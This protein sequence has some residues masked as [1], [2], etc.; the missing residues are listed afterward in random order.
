MHS[1][2]RRTSEL[3]AKRLDDEN[4]SQATAFNK[5]CSCSALFSV[6]TS[7]CPVWPSPPVETFLEHAWTKRQSGLSCIMDYSAL[8]KLCWADECAESPIRWTSKANVTIRSSWHFK[9]CQCFHLVPCPQ[10]ARLFSPS[11]EVIGNALVLNAPAV[12][13]NT[14]VESRGHRNEGKASLL[15]SKESEIVFGLALGKILLLV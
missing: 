11:Q 4:E 8:N 15:F 7:Q 13:W 10:W 14:S 3:W 1:F 2:G 5:R 9:S 6:H 12:S